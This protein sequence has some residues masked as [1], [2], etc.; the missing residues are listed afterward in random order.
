[1]K[2]KRI[3]ILLVVFMICLSAIGVNVFAD[4]PPP[5]PPY[6]A[7]NDMGAAVSGYVEMSPPLTRKY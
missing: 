3:G 4:S 6:S 7:V 2:I 5:R 1:M